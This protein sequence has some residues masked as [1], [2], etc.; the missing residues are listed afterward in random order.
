[1][2]A[3]TIT[4]SLKTHQELEELKKRMNAKSFD[5]LL[6]LLAEE[7]IGV[8]KSMFG[9]VKGIRRSFARECC[10]RTF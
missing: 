4:V 8:Q 3:K 10:Q 6:A 9:A 5:E 1:M 2:N 7:K